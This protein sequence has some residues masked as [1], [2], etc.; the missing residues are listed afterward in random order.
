MLVKRLEVG[1]L[2]TNCYIVASEAGGEGMIVDPGDEA[3]RIVKAVRG[4]KVD[5]KYIVLTHGHWD[6][7]GSLGEVREA[8]GARVA[9]HADDAEFLSA[10]SPAAMFSAS[11]VSV[12]PD[13]LL[14]DGDNIDIGDLRL[15]VLHT[16]GHTPG[17]I[18]LLGN[19]MV[20]TGDTL[21]N[22]GIGRT[23][24]P[25]GSYHQLISG[26]QAKLMVLPDSTIAYPGHGPETTIGAERRG[27]PF[28]RGDLR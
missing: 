23:D 9:I 17:G 27:N 14:K 6:H 1:P 24:L 8:T 25:R 18:C 22:A 19:G 16:P 15:L 20:F 2:G 10:Q 5:I 4:L 11:S 3:E 21:F 7:I 13:R 26:I 28:L 12:P